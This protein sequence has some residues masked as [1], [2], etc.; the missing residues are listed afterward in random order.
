MSGMK[1]N[2][3]PSGH[4]STLIV[5]LAELLSLLQDYSLELN[6]RLQLAIAC[7]YQAFLSGNA[8]AVQMTTLPSTPLVLNFRTTPPLAS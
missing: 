1:H 8:H 7:R 5:D 2:Q 6:N 4:P 3:P